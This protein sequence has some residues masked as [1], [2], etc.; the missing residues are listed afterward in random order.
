MVSKF[1]IEAHKGS[2]IY[3]ILCIDSY[4]RKGYLAY[5]VFSEIWGIRELE[6]EDLEHKGF[7]E[8][9]DGLIE[10]AVKVCEE[11]G[12]ILMSY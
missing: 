9:V 12:G 6:S 4:D 8:V 11:N 1:I 5:Y 3:A 10:I 2:Q 7:R